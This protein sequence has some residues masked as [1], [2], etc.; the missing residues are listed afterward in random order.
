MKKIFASFALMMILLLFFTAFSSCAKNTP[1][2]NETI[3]DTYEESD[4]SQA[5]DGNTEETEGL[6]AGGTE[7]NEVEPKAE[8]SEETPSLTLNLTEDPA[9]PYRYAKG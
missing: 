3:Q 4:L 2:P 1:H 8:Q 7:E 9:P 5:K 6:N